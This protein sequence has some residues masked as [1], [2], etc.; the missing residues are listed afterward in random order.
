MA[1]LK[2]QLTRMKPGLALHCPLPA[3]AMHSSGFAHESDGGA[4]ALPPLSISI[5]SSAAA[6]AV[7]LAPASGASGGGGGARKATAADIDRG[8]TNHSKQR[9][10]FFRVLDDG[11]QERPPLELATAAAAFSS[12]FDLPMRARLRTLWKRAV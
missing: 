12:F 3:H 7:R 11:N 4:S 1:Q 2:A 5:A 6:A 9:K 10:Y 8:I